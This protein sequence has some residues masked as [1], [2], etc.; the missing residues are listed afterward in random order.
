NLKARLTRA[1]YQ[2]RALLTMSMLESRRMGEPGMLRQLRAFEDRVVQPFQGWVRNGRDQAAA[3]QHARRDNG[4]AASLTVDTAVYSDAACGVS[5]RSDL[6]RAAVL[7][8][9]S[10]QP[11]SAGSISGPPAR[12]VSTPEITIQGVFHKHCR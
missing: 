1:R 3:I 7:N 4:G 5:N 6:A 9:I 10:T 8:A 2:R 12:S 11:I